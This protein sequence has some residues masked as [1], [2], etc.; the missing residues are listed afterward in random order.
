MEQKELAVELRNKTGK[1]VS[2]QLRMNGLI[3]GVVYGKGMEPVPV[4]IKPKEL[5]AVVAGEGGQ[6]NLIVL[7]G[8]GSLDGATVIVADILRDALRG[9]L[10]H[11]DLHKIVLTDKLRVHV[12][13]S[14]VGTAV[15]VK[16]GG[17][18]D[19][20]MHSLDVECLPTQIPDHIEIDVTALTL[21]HSIH[22]SE[23][24]LPAGVRVLD[25]PKASVVS[26]LGRAKEETP[27]AG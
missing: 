6:N 23:L 22:V 27:A 14:F 26:I 2:R 20:V 7:K 24:Q 17:M 4:T 19:V 18:L 11:A 15:G 5:G 13:V 3:P 12:P 21:G 16:E 1:G 25:D 10:M 8:G 9:D